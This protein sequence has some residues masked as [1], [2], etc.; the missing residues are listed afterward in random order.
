MKEGL[1]AKRAE[2]PKC[3][4]DIKL[5]EKPG[6]ADGYEWR[7]RK[8]RQLNEH[9]IKRS[10]K[11]DSWFESSHLSILQM[12]KV[13]KYWHGKCPQDFVRNELGVHEHAIVD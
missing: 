1:I 12:L 10:V 4:C 6:R 5:Y 13:T 2:C 3:G 8:H 9:D 7:C 11:R